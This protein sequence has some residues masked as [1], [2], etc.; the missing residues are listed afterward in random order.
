MLLV[1]T[2]SPGVV[3]VPG[4]VATMHVGEFGVTVVTAPVRVTRKVPVRFCPVMVAVVVGS[5]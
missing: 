4:M 5:Q 3:T 1:R 2:T